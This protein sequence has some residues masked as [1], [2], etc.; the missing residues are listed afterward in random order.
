MRI[1]SPTSGP[2]D[3]AY[4]NE[5]EF[6]M[7]EAF[8][9]LV[10]LAEQAGWSRNVVARSVLALAF[11]HTAAGFAEQAHLQQRTAR[12]TKGSH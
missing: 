6:A 9:Q 4:D 8:Q 12:T 2:D 10:S 7:S 11:A 1:S 3:P 5:C